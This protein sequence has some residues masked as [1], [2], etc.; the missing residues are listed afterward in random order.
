MVSQVKAA[1]EQVGI[2]CVLRNEYAGG[3]MG[4]LAPIDAWVELWVVRD[5]DFDGAKAVVDKLQMSVD[6]PDWSCPACHKANPA[7]FE[8]CWSCGAAGCGL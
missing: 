8:T 2:E 4:E 3:A 5:R 7:T 1:V 6:E